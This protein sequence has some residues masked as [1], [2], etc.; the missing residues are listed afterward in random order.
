MEKLRTEQEIA[1]LYVTHDIA[2]ARYF[3]NNILVMYAGHIV[4]EAGGEELIQD[5]NG[6]LMGHRDGCPPG[7]REQHQQ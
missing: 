5:P 4:E 1:F 7:R 6:F 2:T 3:A